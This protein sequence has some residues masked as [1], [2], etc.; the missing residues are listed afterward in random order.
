MKFCDEKGITEDKIREYPTSNQHKKTEHKHYS[1]YYTEQWMIDLVA[2]KHRDYI[3][4][5]GYKFERDEELNVK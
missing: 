3:E 1:H 2:E 5:F 4:Y